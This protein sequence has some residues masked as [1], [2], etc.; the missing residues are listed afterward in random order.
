[1]KQAID[2]IAETTD[3]SCNTVPQF[4]HEEEPTVEVTDETL[5]KECLHDNDVT[6]HFLEGSRRRVI[7]SIL[8]PYQK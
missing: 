8:V 6:L 2:P 5:E 7:Y 3:E 4:Q 1:M